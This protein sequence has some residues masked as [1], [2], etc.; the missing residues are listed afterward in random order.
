MKKI[1]KRATACLLAV[2]MLAG[3]APV[4]RVFAAEAVQPET[5]QAEEDASVQKYTVYYLDLNGMIMVLM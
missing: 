3:E 2:L 1:L 5:E 4:Q